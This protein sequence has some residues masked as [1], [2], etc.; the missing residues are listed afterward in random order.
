M[1]DPHAWDAVI[2]AEERLM[3]Q[4]YVGRRTVGVRPALLCIDLYSQVF[5]DRKEPL[6]EAIERFPASCGPSAWDAKEPIARILDAARSAGIPVA[7][8]TGESRPASQLG[9]ATQR[10]RDRDDPTVDGYAILPE[11]APED[12]EYVVVKTRASAFFGTPLSTWLRMRD[13][14]TLLVVGESTSGCVRASV[15]DGYSHGFKVIVCEEGVFDRA[16]LSHSMSLFDMHHKYATVTST[17]RVIGYLQEPSA[18]FPIVS[19]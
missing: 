6:H 15:V 4:H 1:V 2:G 13:V 18:D 16:P 7:H 11:F 3:A 17:E 9:G 10:R 14:D 8:T 12:G 19:R 5:G